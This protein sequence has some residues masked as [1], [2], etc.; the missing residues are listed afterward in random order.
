MDNYL[1]EQVQ[2][3]LYIL[4][5]ME[6]TFGQWYPQHFD[7]LPEEEQENLS[8]SEMKEAKEQFS[9]MKLNL[10]L[11]EYTVDDYDY[12]QRL[13]D[14]VVDNEQYFKALNIIIYALAEEYG[15]V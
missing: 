15:P 10:E 11:G 8:K 5:D 9:R 3:A 13:I 4:N 14:K 1:Y 2:D 7:F 12:L 6:S